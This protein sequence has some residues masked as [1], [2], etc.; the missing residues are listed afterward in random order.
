M[1]VSRAD[2]FFWWCVSVLLG[3]AYMMTEKVTTSLV[4]A[5]VILFI[6]MIKHQ[7]KQIVYLLLVVLVGLACGATGVYAQDWSESKQV[8]IRNI[9]QEVLIKGYVTSAPEKKINYVRYNFNAE[10]VNNTI[11]P[12]GQTIKVFG[13]ID[14]LVDLGDELS[15]LCRVEVD[16]YNAHD[17]VCLYPKAVTKIGERVSLVQWLSYGHKQFVDTLKQVYPA[18]E[19]A[20]LSGILV[21]G[22]SSFSNKMIDQ[23]KHTGTLHLV[24]LSGFNISII[25]GYLG[26]LFYQLAVPRRWY[27]LL[28]G[29]SLVLFVLTVGPSESVVRASVM[30]FLVVLARHRGRDSSMRNVLA[31]TAVLMV[32]H[33]PTVLL[34]D[35]GFQLSFMA[36]I[37]IVYLMPVLEIYAQRLP[38]LW[39]FK[40]ALLMSVAAE[41]MV[42]PILLLQFEELAIFSPFVN[43][44][45]GPLIPMAMLFG[46]VGTMLGLINI[47]LGQI[48]G[49][50][51]WVVSKI[52]LQIIEWCSFLPM[53][54]L[55][56]SVSALWLIIYYCLIFWVVTKLSLQNKFSRSRT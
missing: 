50:V 48:F 54:V 45:V 8:L 27:M 40:E 37:G 52:I 26:L 49:L 15:M 19:S 20:L 1:I 13:N 14:D 5:S 38:S 43:M 34:S 41:V 55:P 23:F 30:G 22:T 44:L 56:F 24:A 33:T 11:L 36:T 7:R 17:F 4:V 51:G 29:V 35:I 32:M 18:P 28:I 47:S 6:V 42:L 53:L 39:Q 10:Q 3:V 25:I 9:N 16:K 12:H 21:G 31:V 46:F 2:L